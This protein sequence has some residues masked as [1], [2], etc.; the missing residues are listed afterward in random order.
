MNNSIITI[1]NLSCSYNLNDQDKV[2]FINNLEIEKGKIIFLLG[3]SG[4]GKST[5]LETIGLMNNTIA[6]GDVIVHGNNQN[7]NYAKLWANNSSVQL[8]QLRKEFLS[9]IFQ[10]TNL[11]EN[12][13][14]YENICLS[15]MIKSGASQAEAMLGAELL[16]NKVGLPESKVGFNTLSVN[17]SGGQRQRVSFVRALNTSFKI[18]LCDEP[19]GNLDEVNANELLNIV[20]QNLNDDKTAII[21]SHDVN[22][23][24]KHADKIIVITKHPEQNYGEVLPEN[25]FERNNWQRL[26]TAD[27]STFRNKLVGFF[28]AGKN[29]SKAVEE[30]KIAGN[31]KLEKTN[32]KNLFANKE[33]NALYGKS[34]LNLIILTAIIS[35]TLLAIGFANGTL[36]YLS[37][38]LNDTFVNYLAVEIPFAKNTPSQVK[39]FLDQLNS[40]E[41][42]SEFAV[43]TITTYKVVRLDFFDNKTNESNFIQGRVLDIDDPLT[44]VLFGEKNKESGDVKFKSDRDLGIVVTTKFLK[45]LG[46]SDNARVIYLNNGDAL[47]DNKDQY[48][49]VPIPIRAIVKEIP[50]KN[51]FLITEFF[52]RCYK[53]MD[54][55]VFSMPSSQ[56]KRVLYFVENDNELA[57][58]FRTEL[59]SI[60][61]DFSFKEVRHVKAKNQSNDSTSFEEFDGLEKEQTLGLNINL[62]TCVYF[63]VSG[64]EI[65]LNFDNEPFNYETCLKVIEQIENLNLYKQNNTK[66]HR[67]LDYNTATIDETE[68]TNDY[69]CI[70]LKGGGSGLDKIESFANYMYKTLNDDDIKG[71]NNIEVDTGAVKEKKNF[72]YISKMTLL[73]SGLLIVFA[74]LAISLFISNLLKTHLNKVK[75]NLG[76]YKA[77]GLSNNESQSIYLKIMIK[78]ISIAI[79][80]ALFVALILG[81][82]IEKALE[83]LLKVEDQ[84]KY[85]ILADTITYIMLTVIIGVTILVSFINI[86][87]ILSKTPGDLIYNR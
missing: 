21:V 2:L 66:I 55:C 46:Y 61:K 50:G 6:S 26:N 65:S 13:T 74:V 19:T 54:G 39:E 23:A 53:V 52:L 12:F 59:K 70:N 3:A 63:P 10:N 71:Q 86:K 57:K 84:S 1:S 37:E 51:N 28:E 80:L 5:L 17:L 14:A 72:N 85:F 76:T 32:Y 75:M 49:K 29:E 41:V 35:I 30:V 43:N 18:L 27:I 58:S 7:I 38:K 9:F 83:S 62:D 48:Y 45:S 81:S 40:K 36:K 20:R 42:K 4:S 16:M 64:Y 11:M 60:F 68:I 33:G 22:L 79:S 82:I 34:R 78:F 44:S 31:A 77:F 24:L 56:K 67:I 25:I 73:I 47:N 87:K 8:D 15:Q 69:L